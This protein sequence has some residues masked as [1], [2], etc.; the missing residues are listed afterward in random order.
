M[1]LEVIHNKIKKLSPYNFNIHTNFHP[2]RF[3][4]K[5][6]RN[7]KLKSRKDVILVGFEENKC[8]KH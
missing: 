5:C 7:K 1:T 6:A 3:I 4:N 2:N 8:F